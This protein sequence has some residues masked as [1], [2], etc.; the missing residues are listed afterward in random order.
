MRAKSTPAIRLVRRGLSSLPAR[1]PTSVASRAT[2]QI[3]VETGAS[4]AGAHAAPELDGDRRDIVSC[5]MSALPIDEMRLGDLLTFLAVLRSESISSAARE[6]GVSPSQVSK[7]V[8]RLESI[9]KV[10]LLSRNSRGVALTEAG[11]MARPHVEDAI[12]HLRA[13]GEATH[14]SRLTVAAPSSLI[15]SFLPVI[16][17]C[18]REVQVR[19]LVLPPQLLRADARENVFDATFVTADRDRLPSSWVSAPIGE[20][21]QGLFGSPTLASRLGPQPV[22]VP[23]LRAMAFVTPVYNADGRYVAVADDCPLPLRDR[24]VGH[25]A[26]TLS[27]AM[28]LAVGTD[29]LVFGPVVAAHDHVR[30]GRLVEVRVEGWNVREE[31]YFACDGERILS[32]VQQA[33]VKAL[34]SALAAKDRSGRAGEKGRSASE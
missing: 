24:V 18:T 15:E 6:L 5:G 19:G 22:P 3:A 25:Q 21:R 32:R 8:A 34:R 17:A 12:A 29:Q 14:T 1:W 4:A 27:L 30:A 13:V 2:A 16:A 9:W 10:R 26:Q 23:R 11:Q 31:L 7:A 20:L 28:A 33:I